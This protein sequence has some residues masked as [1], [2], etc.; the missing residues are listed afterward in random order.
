MIKRL[1]EEGAAALESKI[2]A[3][4]EASNA[5]WRGAFDALLMI[6]SVLA[7]GYAAFVVAYFWKTRGPAERNEISNLVRTGS[8]VDELS[9]MIKSTWKD[10]S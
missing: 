6:V 7:F 8:V 9:A 2:D 4:I 1:A 3:K 5:F 10:D